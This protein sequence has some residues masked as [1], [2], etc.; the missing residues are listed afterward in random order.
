MSNFCRT[1]FTVLVACQIVL[2]QAISSEEPDIA[3]AREIIRDYRGAINCESLENLS[4]KYIETWKVN[5]SEMSNIKNLISSGRLLKSEDK[6][7][8]GDAVYNRTAVLN[9][10]RFYREYTTPKAGTD[11]KK[12]DLSK[13][14]S[15]RDSEVRT[16]KREAFTLLFPIT[17]SAPWYSDLRLVYKGIAQAGER[18]AYVLEG[19]I[20]PS[21]NVKL[22]FDITS[23]LVV[24]W[25]LSSTA[26]DGK[27]RVQDHYLSNHKEFKGCRVPAVEMFEDQ[28]FKLRIEIIDFAKNLKFDPLFF[29]GK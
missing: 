27:V 11:V 8:P 21:T 12:L 25:K 7:S 13:P 18:K 23:K 10:S 16:L 4:V 14:E 9:E 20:G 5:N 29:D 26:S 2:G 17:L 6:N 1:I 22:L 3:R 24:L 19:D 28:K 15:Q